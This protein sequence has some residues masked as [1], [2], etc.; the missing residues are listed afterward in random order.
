MFHKPLRSQCVQPCQQQPCPAVASGLLSSC[1]N[2]EVWHSDFSIV[3]RPLRCN[4]LLWTAA[5]L[6]GP[7]PWCMLQYFLGCNMKKKA[8]LLVF[9]FCVLH[10]P[11]CSDFLAAYGNI[12]LHYALWH[13]ANNTQ[14]VAFKNWM[15]FRSDL[16][17]AGKYFFFM[18]CLSVNLLHLDELY[19]TSLPSKETVVK[20][21]N[22]S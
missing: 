10:S 13:N 9:L 7:K 22:L 20:L 16:G 8:V 19:R 5:P 14:V 3:H 18:T 2:G 4:K 12:M 11:V 6:K 21:Y 15:A 17:A 1:A